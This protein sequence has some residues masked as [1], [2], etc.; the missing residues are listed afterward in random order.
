MQHDAILWRICPPSVHPENKISTPKWTFFVHSRVD[1]VGT[2][3]KV[4]MEC[5]KTLRRFSLT[6]MIHT[7][8]SSCLSHCVQHGSDL[9]RR[10]DPVARNVGVDLS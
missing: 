5:K 4:D 6:A 3:T 8:S 7:H 9:C 2:G 1:T 10:E